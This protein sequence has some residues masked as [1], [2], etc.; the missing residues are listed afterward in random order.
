VWPKLR[1]QVAVEMEQ[2]RQLLEAHRPLL[3]KCTS[4]KPDAIERS[5]LAAML[6]SYYNGVENIFQRVAVEVDGKTLKGELWHRQLLENMAQSE[7]NRPAV[8]S[9]ALK[10]KLRAYLEFRHVF[11]HAYTFELRW[12]KMAELVLGCEETFGR[13][14]IEINNFFEKQPPGA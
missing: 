11:R 13:F 7:K 10:V 3:N 14:E 5:A 2:I 12:E 9:E 4:V 1:K 6:H 8:V